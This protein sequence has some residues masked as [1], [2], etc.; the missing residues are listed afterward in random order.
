[1]MRSLSTNAFGQPSETKLTLGTR[2]VSP[3]EGRLS[4]ARGYP[5]A[6]AGASGPVERAASGPSSL[7]IHDCRLYRISFATKLPTADVPAGA[8]ARAVWARREKS[9]AGFHFGGWVQRGPLAR[10]GKGRPYLALGP[11]KWAIAVSAYGCK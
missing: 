1:M 7:N 5:S 6:P 9:L 11:R 8:R 3:V 2:A 4:M 10:A